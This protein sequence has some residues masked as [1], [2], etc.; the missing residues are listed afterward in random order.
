MSL[1][2]KR[3]P[4]SLFIHILFYKMIQGLLYS[5][6]KKNLVNFQMA[7]KIKATPK[8]VNE[9]LGATLISIH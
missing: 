7:K 5:P 9:D 2:R 4:L 8:A 6:Y 1:K 3:I